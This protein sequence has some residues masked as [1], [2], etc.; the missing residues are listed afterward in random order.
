[1]R[2]HRR[3]GLTALATIAS[4]AS[5]SVLAAACGGDDDDEREQTAR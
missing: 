2:N 3:R 4:L 5:V 1:M